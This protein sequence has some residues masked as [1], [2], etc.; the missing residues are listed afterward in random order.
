MDWPDFYIRLNLYQ[1]K[2]YW[3]GFYTHYYSQAELG[4]VTLNI[5]HEFTEPSNNGMKIMIT[6][7]E[8]SPACDAFYFDDFELV[9]EYPTLTPT[10]TPTPTATPTATPTG[11]PTPTPP[12]PSVG[13]SGTLLPLAKMLM[14]GI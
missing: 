6:V 14:G 9:W 3:S 10:P 5:N 11:T 7:S 8:D 1:W 4:D 2:G 13:G 12:P